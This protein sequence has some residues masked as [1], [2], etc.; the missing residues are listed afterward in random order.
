[1]TRRHDP[2]QMALSLSGVTAGGAICGHFVS[3]GR[4]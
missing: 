4:A 3:E 2:D 1:M